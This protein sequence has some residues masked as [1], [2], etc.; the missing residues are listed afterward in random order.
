[1]AVTNAERTL[2][3]FALES[4]LPAMRAWRRNPLN[5]LIADKAA[6]MV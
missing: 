1:L 5:I 2:P 4:D 6:A 3:F